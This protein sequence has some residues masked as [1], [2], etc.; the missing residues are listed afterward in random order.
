MALFSDRK[1]ASV[2]MTSMVDVTFL[3]LIFFMVTA[4]FTMQKSFRIPAP[5]QEAPSTQIRQVEEE[6]GAIV[7]RI[8]EFS[9]FFVSA[10]NWD[11]EEEAPSEQELLRRLR[12]AKQGDG[13]SPPPNTLIVE[14][15]G[16]AMYEKVIMALDAGTEVGIQ[17]V[18]LRNIDDDML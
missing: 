5:D 18:K 2:E 16:D 9:T 10:P 11:E 7:V 15:H 4:A 17:E 6:D 3:L 8:D 13:H 12:E 1:G 14:A